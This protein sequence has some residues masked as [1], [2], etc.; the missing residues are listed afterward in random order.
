[1]IDIDSL[2]AAAQNGNVSSAAKAEKSL[3][4]DFDNF[5]TLLTA[6]L[7][8][9]DPL[10]PMD[11]NEFT[12]QIVSFTQLEQTIGQ[13]KNLENLVSLHQSNQASNAIGYIGKQVEATTNLF[14]IKDSQPVDVAYFMPEMAKAGTLQI[15]NQRDQLVASLTL[16]KEAGW[17]KQKLDPKD[18]GGNIE[19]G[20]YSFRV[21]AVNLDEV[22]I[23]QQ[24]IAY[25]VKGLV[26]SVE[27]ADAQTTLSMNGAPVALEKVVRVNM[28]ENENQN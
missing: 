1:M 11:N 5:L 4:K 10:S 13:N 14:Q 15:F 6:Q 12:N 2:N 18:L 24:D 7:Q 28:P 23:E 22:P 20:T 21:T 25:Q 16:N 3:A 26:T 9:Q 27:Y 17:H 19:D 8:N